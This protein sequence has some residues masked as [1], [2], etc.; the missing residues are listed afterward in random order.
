M[1]QQLKAHSLDAVSAAGS[2]DGG[3]SEAR[4]TLHSISVTL[5]FECRTRA[6]SGRGES[7]GCGPLHSAADLLPVARHLRAGLL[8]SAAPAAH[9]AAWQK[10]LLLLGQEMAQYGG[11]LFN[12]ALAAVS[13]ATRR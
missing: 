9:W 6:S 1:Q 5:R 11:A 7:L 10:A 3:S 13:T 4:T 12:N 2:S 8:S